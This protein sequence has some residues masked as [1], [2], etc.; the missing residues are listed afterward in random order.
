MRAQYIALINLVSLSA[1]GMVQ[2]E[3]AY[4]RS[5]PAAGRTSPTKFTVQFTV[6]AAA[7]SVVWFEDVSDAEGDL[8]RNSKTWSNCTI[9][10]RDNWHC[11][12]ITDANVGVLEQISMRNGRLAQIYWGTQRDFTKQ[13]RIRRP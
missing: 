3:Y 5:T 13:Y 7:K 2:T 6:D 4:T 1:C 10:D 9:L 11:P 12:P 8:G